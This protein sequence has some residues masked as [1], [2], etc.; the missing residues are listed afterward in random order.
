MLHYK[1][2]QQLSLAVAETNS[3]PETHFIGDIIYLTGQKSLVIYCR[4]V[5]VGTPGIVVTSPLSSEVLG[6]AKVFIPAMIK[7]KR[8]ET[9]ISLFVE[10]QKRENDNLRAF[11]SAWS[12]L[13]LVVNRLSKVIRSEWEDLVETEVLPTWDRKLSGVPQEEYRMRDRFF[14]VACVM[15]LES[16]SCDSEMF[17]RINNKRSGYYHRLD[18]QEKDLPTQDAQTLF[19]KYLKLGLLYISD[20]SYE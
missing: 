10:S 18:V 13:E 11:I 14:S 16:A 4:A 5:S 2:Q 12:A 3:S 9:A 6:N 7:E 1:V 15:N 19:R 8:I 20:I 17:K